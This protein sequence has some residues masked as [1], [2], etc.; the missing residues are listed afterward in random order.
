MN[1]YAELH[2]MPE[3]FT[4][5]RLLARAPR[6]GDG[7]LVNASVAEAFAEL[8]QWMP[9]A[10]HQPSLAESETHVRESAARFR[11]REEFNFLLLRRSDDAHVGN[12]GVHSIDWHVPCFELGYWLRTSMTGQGYM[13][14]AVLALT[15][16][17]FGTLGAERVEIRCD[18]ANRAS[19]AV[20]ERAG[21]ALEARLRHQ[22]RDNAGRLADTLIYTRFPAGDGAH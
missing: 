11:A 13:T 19:A 12:L 2:P 7:R 1:L 9:W 8:S 17:L 18:A 6:M 22:R 10:R 21:Y 3:R 15:A 14:E 4:S 16:I 5:E 20:A